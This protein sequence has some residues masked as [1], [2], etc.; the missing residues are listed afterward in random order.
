MFYGEERRFDGEAAAAGLGEQV[1]LSA[2]PAAA[3][4]AWARLLLCPLL[5]PM[6]QRSAGCCGDVLGTSA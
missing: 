3:C 6:L 1:Q 2:L 4:V 5:S